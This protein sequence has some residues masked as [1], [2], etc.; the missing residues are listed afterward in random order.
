MNSIIDLNRKD[1][2]KVSA[3][4]KFLDKS[5]IGKILELQEDIMKG[6]EDKQLYVA[7]SEDEFINYFNTGKAIGYV[8]KDTKELVA[9]GVYRNVGLKEDNYGHDLGLKDEE[10][11]N[12]GQVELTIV[13]EEFRGNRLQKILCQHLEKIAKENKTP[14]MCA[15]ASPYNKHSVN[16]FKALGY[17]VEKD[18]LKYGGLRRYV[19]VKD[20]Y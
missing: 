16:T 19:L 13:K 11:L 3:E 17:R 5:Y 20:L 7:S 6:I 15:T 18:K 14:I 9:V 12:V 1:G 10:L 4:L 2:A 8:T